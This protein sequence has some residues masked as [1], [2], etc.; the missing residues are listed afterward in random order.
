MAERLQRLP[1]GFLFMR[2]S[3]SIRKAAPAGL[4][5][6]LF[7]LGAITLS[8]FGFHLPRR[9]IPFDTLIV[10]SRPDFFLN[11]ILFLP[12]GMILDL[13][14]P[15]GSLL[16]PLWKV[17]F[18][19]AGVSLT[20]ELLQFFLP[21][22]YPSLLDLIANTLGGGIGFLSARSIEGRGWGEKAV[23]QRCLLMRTLLSFYLL[24]LFS[25]AALSLGELDRWGPG[26]SFW[27]GSGPNREDRWKGKLD[28]LAV[29]DR[30]FGLQEVLRQYRSAFQA[31]SG[32]LF[33]HPPIALYPDSLF[34]GG[35]AEKITQ[36]ISVT[37]RFTIEAWIDQTGGAKKGSGRLISLAIPPDLDYLIIQQEKDHWFFEVRNR[38]KKGYPHLGKITT[39][40]LILPERPVHLV[41]VYDVGKMSFY[42]NGVLV[43][44][45]ILSDGLFTLAGFMGFDTTR[46]D[47]RGFFA[48]LLFLPVGFLALF[49]LRDRS[50]GSVGI[51]SLFLFL[52]FGGFSLLQAGQSLP[53]IS[54]RYYGLP[55]LAISLGGYLGWIALGALQTVSRPASMR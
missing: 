54:G 43:A 34:S 42:L 31:A 26:A 9:S 33:T 50:P 38:V 22:R 27:V 21:E 3:S 41:A 32:G 1:V 23:A 17:L 39:K 53:F 20:V 11:I 25:L 10:F 47:E 44:D 15:P 13:L 29:Y 36:R 18:F 40:R 37:N 19:S 48:F 8:P 6:Y 30:A 14:F 24:L 45:A 51:V 7:Y 46:P 28:F 4:I 55:L 12:L 16:R 2:S 49:S 35:P 5:F 52:L